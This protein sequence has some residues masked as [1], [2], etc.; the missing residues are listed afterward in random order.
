MLFVSGLHSRYTAT[1]NAAG[2]DLRIVAADDRVL[3]EA[4][5]AGERIYQF[6]TIPH[7]TYPGLE[8][9][10]NKNGLETL[11]VGATLFAR[12]SWAARHGDANAHLIDAI[13]RA[14]PAILERV[15]PR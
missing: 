6:R 13:Q 4:R 10:G 8:V 14:K 7:G 1:G 2:D 12:Q 3:D 15:A 5:F 9:T 11:T